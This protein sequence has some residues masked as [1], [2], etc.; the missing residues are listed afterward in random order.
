MEEFEQIHIDDI[1]EGDLKVTGITVMAVNDNHE[2]V[3]ISFNEEKNAL[4]VVVL[5]TYIECHVNWKYHVLITDISGV[6]DI[7]GPI[8]KVAMNLGFETQEKNGMLIPK[9]N[10]Q[11][12]DIDFDRGN[13]HF[14][15][16]CSFCPGDLVNLILE[17]FKGPLIDKIRDEARSAINQKVIGKVNEIIMDKYP[18]TQELTSEI[19]MGLATTGPVVVKSDYLSGPIDGTVFLTAEGY[20][21]PYDAPEIPTESH[22]NP[23]EILLFVSKYV[24]QT[25]NKTM[26]KVPLNFQTSVMGFNINIDVDGSKVPLDFDTRDGELHISG[27]AIVTIPA[28]NLAFELGASSDIDLFFKPGDS[29]NMIYID[30]DSDKKSLKITLFVMKIFGFRIDLTPFTSILNMIIGFV[31]NSFVLPDIAV[32]KIEALPMTATSAI[33]KFLDKYT[34]AGIAFNFGLDN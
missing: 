28:V 16:D 1:H 29:T 11:D 27:G 31:I 6:G 33:V 3:Q 17:L 26:N 32:K 14:N 10:I 20:N 34:E 8:S 2:N 21:R 19:S 18:L 23:G 22:E 13:F 7:K 24:Y 30:P 12:F 5:N 4:S 25:F 15:F 9:V